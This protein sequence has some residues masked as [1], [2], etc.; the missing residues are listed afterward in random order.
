M[1]Y[2]YAGDANL[3]GTIDG[4]DLLAFRTGFFN[5]QHG[6]IDPAD[7]N[8]EQGD[9]NYDGKING[10]DLLILRTNYYLTHTTGL[11]DPKIDSAFN[12]LAAEIKAQVAVPEPGLLTVMGAAIGLLSLRRR[13]AA[14]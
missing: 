8:W 6:Y 4:A 11:Y 3:D 12:Q 13:R 7:V 14:R 9:F 10:A 5:L 1:R 2:T